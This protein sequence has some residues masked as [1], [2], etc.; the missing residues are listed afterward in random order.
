MQRVGKSRDGLE[1][2]VSAVDETAVVIAR[3]I[4]FTQKCVRDLIVGGCGLTFLFLTFARE[5]NYRN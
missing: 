1:N 5:G 2:L 3:G 4:K